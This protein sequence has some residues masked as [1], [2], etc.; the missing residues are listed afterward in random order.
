MGEVGCLV[1]LLGGS[2]LSVDIAGVVKN[3]QVTSGLGSQVMLVWYLGISGP[4]TF[5][6]SC[7]YLYKLS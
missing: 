7:G 1:G 6:I 2:F 3:I 4:C 5:Q